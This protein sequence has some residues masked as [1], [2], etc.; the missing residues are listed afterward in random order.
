MVCS[1]DLAFVPGNDLNAEAV[2]D[3]NERQQSTPL[4]GIRQIHRPLDNSELEFKEPATV[5]T[6]APGTHVSFGYCTGM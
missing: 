4:I 5:D 1:K 3:G 2:E 6:A